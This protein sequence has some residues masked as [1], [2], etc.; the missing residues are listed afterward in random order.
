[1][2]LTERGRVAGAV[3]GVA[4]GV[5]GLGALRVATAVGAPSDPSAG[6]DV[7]YPTVATPLLSAR[8]APRV[9]TDAVARSRLDAA[10]QAA[11][12]GQNA[13]A[14][15]ALPGRPGGR[16]LAAV[17][18]DHDL[19]P[20]STL[21]LVT[22]VTAIERLG[23]DHRF[24]TVARSVAPPDSDG[25]VRGD[26]ALV[27]SGDP[28]LATPRYE[29]YVRS[30]PRLAADPLTALQGIV[31]QF[32]A[33]GV[34]RVDGAIVGD[35]TRFS[36][37]EYLDAWK[38]SYRSEGQV[39]PISALTVNH[40]F[41]AFPPPEPVD[42]AAAYAAG[43]LTILLE[44]AGIAVAAESR[45]G[46]VGATTVD[47]AVLRSPPLSEIVAGMLT[48]SDNTTAEMLL[49]ATAFADG[50]TP[51][52]PGGTAIA[53]ETLTGLGVSDTTDARMVDGSGLARDDRVSCR[54]LIDTLLAAD[55]NGFGAVVDGLADAGMSGTLATR[56]VGHPLAGR[57]HAKT[58]QLDGV[59]ALA[60]M[61]DSA[62][63]GPP[64]WFAFVT[65]GEFSTTDGQ[66]RQQRVAEAVASYP[67][68][69]PA[70]ALAPAP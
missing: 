20:A 49:R 27:G 11:V 21:K 10:L 1:M 14:A 56:F 43:Q 41:G 59:A 35:G 40:G 50:A 58:G 60:G 2:A 48:A 15:V 19:T 63:G 13:C 69:P 25:V 34:T 67:D 57:L 39:G 65:N 4:L 47:L 51:D 62:T 32:R 28:T 36:G 23:A 37:P 54:L 3:L 33:A 6:V 7:S 68:S 22:A 53:V 16:L 44:R 52:T 26:V 18:A 24:A 31:D 8:R 55:A 66:A 38:A 42:D 45:S 64:I 61:I 9:L 12:A 70:D 29:E 46:S 17:D 5:G 30:T